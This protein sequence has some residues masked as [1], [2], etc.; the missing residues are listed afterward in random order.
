MGRQY[1]PKVRIVASQASWLALD[2]TYSQRHHRASLER[3]KHMVNRSERFKR[4]LWKH[5]RQFGRLQ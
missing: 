3:R 4:T 5:A 1:L 2:V